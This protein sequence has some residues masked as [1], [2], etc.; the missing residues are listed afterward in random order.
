MKTVAITRKVSPAI[1]QCELTYLERTPIDLDLAEQQHAAYEALLARLGCN[2]TS[3]PAEPELADSVFVEDPAIVLDE[4]AI[5]T[6]PG[7]ASRR[8]ERATIAEALAPYRQL[9]HIAA[10]GILDGGDVLRVGKRLWVGLT[11][12]SN[13]AAID[14]LQT[15]LAPY[16][17]SVSGAQVTGCLHLKSAVTHLGNNLL[18]L[19]PAWVDP[20]HFP[21]C[22]HIAVDPSE[23]HAANALAVNGAI[24]YPTS[25]PRTLARL[26]AA[27]LAVHTVPA[28]E[29]IKA[30]GAVTCCSLV[31]EIHD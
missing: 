4:V 26:Q 24:V 22:D 19:N 21:G 23:P 29:L 5:I 31:F 28:T 18:L 20:A 17:Y 15:A 14:Q 1:A 25:Y 30:E 27:G 12:R 9:I 11:A 13:Q 8:P 6:R 10:P 7:A 3:L 2:L 16:G